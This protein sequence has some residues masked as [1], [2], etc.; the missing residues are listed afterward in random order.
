MEVFEGSLHDD[1]TL[2]SQ[3]EKLSRRFAIKEVVVVADRGMIT[4]ANIET[5]KATEGVGWI[6]ALKAPQVKKLVKDGCLQLSL[7]DQQKLAEI[8]SHDY[9]DERLIVCRN[10]L[11]GADR[12]RRREDLLQA[13]ERELAAIHQRV[14][15]GTLTGQAQIA[16]A[17]GPALKRYRVKKHFELEITD[18]TFTYKRKT[19]QI[20][21]QAALDGFYVL[22]TSV[23]A[24][25]L[26]SAEVVRSY[27]QLKEAERDFKTIKG[28]EL[29]IRPIGHR[30]EDRV[31]AHVFL[32]TLACY[33][34][35]HLKASLG[36]AALQRPAPAPPIRPRRQSHPLPRRRAQ[37][38][39][40]PH[41]PRRARALI[42]LPT[43]RARDPDPQHHPRPRQPRHL[44]T[45]HHPNPASS[46]RP[47]A[48][49][50]ATH[51]Q[52]VTTA[53][54]PTAPNPRRHRQ[55]SPITQVTSV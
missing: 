35:W 32:C 53:T 29:E 54:T 24:Q 16:L 10:P 41:H 28:P 9:P 19:E 39:H 6:T 38:A 3:I 34:T 52:V 50:A 51:A 25:T 2:P 15:N 27:K 48:D 42:P 44:P 30:L 21:A 14:Q 26:P 12:T 47:P 45:A 40:P 22:R 18:T 20:N 8:T 31:R 37:S 7:F 17:V 23:S 46:P 43:R 11:V 36:G 1:K 13:T 33:L 49:R 55:N 5:L 4:K